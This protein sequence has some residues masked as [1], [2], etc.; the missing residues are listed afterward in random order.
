MLD[1]MNNLLHSIHRLPTYQLSVMPGN[2][3][4]GISIDQQFVTS[5]INLATV[6]LMRP[7]VLLIRGMCFAERGRCSS[8]SDRACKVSG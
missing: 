4:Q 7:G 5:D 1:I 2:V 6:T 3:V 8:I